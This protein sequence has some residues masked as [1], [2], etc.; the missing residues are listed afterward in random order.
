MIFLDSNIIKSK[1][2]ELGFLDAGIVK[3]EK[4]ELEETNLSAW[5]DKG[6]HGKMGYMENH[7]EKRLDP[8]LLVENANSVIVL[9]YNYFPSKQQNLDAPKIAK[10][11]YGKDYHFVIKEKLNTLLIELQKIN[12]EIEGRFFVDSAPVME[13]QW[14]QRAGLGWLGKN[15]L[16][17]Q[18]QRGSYFFI[19]S[20]ITNVQSNYDTP[21]TDHCG[22]C[23]ACLDACPTNAFE[24]AGVLNASKCISYLT[25]ELKESIPQEFH[26]KMEDW[27]F[28]CDICQDVC[29]WNRFSE[30]HSEPLFEAEG[31]WLNWTRE[32]WKALSREKF[33]QTF[34]NS[35]LKRAG[36]DKIIDSNLTQNQ[37]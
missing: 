26:N 25:I 12:P 33:N 16:L 18:K 36:F 11:A 13:R 3:A 22:N 30:P 1:A 19:A 2:K 8:T 4:L 21:T 28:G 24:Q 37:Q 35:P 29:P 9:L 27:I 20:L 15:T 17:L 7:F 6:Y 23:T 34:K 32:D 31:E 10:Y 14:A 5:L